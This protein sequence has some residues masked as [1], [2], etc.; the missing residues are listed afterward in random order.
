M[1][2]LRSAQDRASTIQAQFAPQHSGRAS[3]R[4]RSCADERGRLRTGGKGCR[5]QREGVAGSHVKDAKRPQRKKHRGRVK[6]S[7]RRL[8]S[9][10]GRQRKQMLAYDVHFSSRL[11]WANENLNVFGRKEHVGSFTVNHM[12]RRREGNFRSRRVIA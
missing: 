1:R 6:R 12:A 8:K 9:V 11:T 10:G 5:E 3:L 2:S 7:G 4:P